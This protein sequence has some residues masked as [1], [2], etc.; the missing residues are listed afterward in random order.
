MEWILW[1]DEGKML[2]KVAIGSKKNEGMDGKS[3]YEIEICGLLRQI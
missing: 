2:G 1:K 3:Q